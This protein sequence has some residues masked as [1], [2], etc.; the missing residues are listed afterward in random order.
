MV[1]NPFF[2]LVPAIPYETLSQLQESP[3]LNDS[4]DYFQSVEVENVQIIQEI[5]S[6]NS[7]EESSQIISNFEPDSLDDI[8]DMDDFETQNLLI[9][10]DPVNTKYLLFFLNL[11]ICL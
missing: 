8:P 10:E 2:L 1:Q 9:T 11:F 5:L 3:I 6:N 7:T 4:L